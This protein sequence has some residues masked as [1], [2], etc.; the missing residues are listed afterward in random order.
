MLV[1]E[2]RPS[3]E[4]DRPEI[5]FQHRKNR[6]N[7]WLTVAEVTDG[8]RPVKDYPTVEVLVAHP[9]ATQ[10]DSYNDSGGRGLFSQKFV[11]TV[12]LA[13]FRGLS[14]LPAKLNG[15]TYY[16]LSCTSQQS[17]SFSKRICLA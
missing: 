5:D 1:Y 2:C 15:V 4:D 12:G 7:G 11:D 9:E 10:W 8:D 13:S 6:S 17:Q 16:F 14:L 3:Y